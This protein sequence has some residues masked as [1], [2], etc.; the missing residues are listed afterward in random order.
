M[1]CVE[2]EVGWDGARHGGENTFCVWIPMGLCLGVCVGGS[3]VD[4][5]GTALFSLSK[6]EVRKHRKRSAEV[7]FLP[8]M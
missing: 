7:F 1:C 5:R 3:G 6:S 2:S 8:V 4:V